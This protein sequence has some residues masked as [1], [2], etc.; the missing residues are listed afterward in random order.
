MKTV[1]E[2]LK[3]K[4]KLIHHTFFN[5][6]EIME[7]HSQKE[8]DE[9]STSSTSNL[10]AGEIF[11]LKL[12]AMPYSNDRVGQAEICNVSWRPKVGSK[13]K[14]NEKDSKEIEL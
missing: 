5:H 7:S 12:R 2:T 14:F 6:Q 11:W 1:L 9:Q 4:Y 13:I 8:T 10:S 3:A